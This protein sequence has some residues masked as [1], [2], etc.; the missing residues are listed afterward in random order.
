MFYE[1]QKLL[2]EQEASYVMV[3]NDEVDENI[4]IIRKLFHFFF[5]QILLNKRNEMI[6]F[7]PSPQPL[8]EKIIPPPPHTHT[9]TY[10]HTRAW[11]IAILSQ[12]QP[13]RRLLRCCVVEIYDFVKFFNVY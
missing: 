10:T 12:S 6:D 11:T 5:T 7:L 4:W 13:N 3:E 1:A 9:H 8:F 2:N